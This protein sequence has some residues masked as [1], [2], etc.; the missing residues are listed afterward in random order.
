MSGNFLKHLCI[1]NNG[2]VDEFHLKKKTQKNKKQKFVRMIEVDI[3]NEGLVIQHN[4]SERTP[5]QC[6]YIIPIL[7]E[8]MLC[9][10]LSD[11]C[12]KSII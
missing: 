6:K 10:S 4:M 5:I 2:R 3:F 9:A 8:G 12:L 7:I 11:N 1:P